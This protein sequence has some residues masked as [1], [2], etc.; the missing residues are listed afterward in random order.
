MSRPWQESAIVNSG[1]ALA[2]INSSR[3]LVFAMRPHSQRLG[4]QTD[5][6]RNA[7]PKPRTTIPSHDSLS[8]FESTNIGCRRSR[9]PSAL[10]APCD[11]TG[12]FS[13][14]GRVASPLPCVTLP[15][16]LLARSDEG[17]DHCSEEWGGLVGAPATAATMPLCDESCDKLG[18]YIWSDDVS[19]DSGCGSGCPL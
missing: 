13:P 11:Y 17:V 2:M 7:R 6:L 8:L 3:A 1:R 18:R 16:C 19:C 9:A 5:R 4:A 14:P 15:R 10:V 12:L